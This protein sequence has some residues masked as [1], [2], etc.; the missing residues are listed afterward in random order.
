[1]EIKKIKVIKDWSEFKSVDNIQVFLGFANFYWQFIQGFSKIAAP[2]TS[3]LKI[4]G[5][6]DEP[7]P[8]RNDGSR[9]AFN[10][11]NDSKPV[12]EKD[13]DNDEVDK[14]SSDSRKHTKKSGKLKK[15]SKS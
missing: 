6:P 10:R 11:N 5:L 15:L 2:L 8:N 13:N 3:I 14:F 9:L 4:T 1:M 7:V 12:F